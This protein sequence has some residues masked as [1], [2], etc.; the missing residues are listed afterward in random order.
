MDDDNAENGLQVS[1]EVKIFL[2]KRLSEFL[3]RYEIAPFSGWLLY[4][5]LL[6]DSSKAFNAQI[7]HKKF[8]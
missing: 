6:Q 5:W 2:S 3:D 1:L 7:K 8:P 4:Y